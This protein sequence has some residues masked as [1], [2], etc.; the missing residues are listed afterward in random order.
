[1]SDFEK[2]KEQLPRKE[3][4]YSLLNSKRISDREYVHALKVWN[5]PYHNFYLTCD[6]L[7]LADTCKKI[8]NNSLK[9]N[10]LCSSH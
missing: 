2:F 3:K 8:R 4:F 9:N 6:I 1:M 7:L 10:G 5:K